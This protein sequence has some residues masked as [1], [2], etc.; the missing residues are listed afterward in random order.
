[1]PDNSLLPSRK[2]DHIK[3]NLENDVQSGISSGFENFHFQHNAIPELDLADVNSSLTLFGK[4]LSAPILISSMTGGTPEAERINHTLALA[5]QKY[6]LAMGVGS[7]RAAIENPDLAYSFQVRKVAPDILLFANLGAVQLNHS[8]TGKHCM[9]AVEMIEADGLFLHL[10][11]LQEALQPEGDTKF[12]GL[13]RQIEQVCK[14]LPVPVMVKEVGWGIS[15]S[16]ARQL[17]DAGVTAIDVAGAGGTSWS[18]VEYFRIKDEIN[19]RIALD[20]KDWGI[21]TADCLEQIASEAPEMMMFA[22]G[23]I[24]TG[25]D[26]AKAINLG[27]SLCG[28]AGPF[29]RAAVES[30]EAVETLIKYLM[31]ELHILQFAT[32]CKTLEDLKELKMYKPGECDR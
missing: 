4:Q 27:A 7:Q 22:S 13:L 5:A 24:K 9:K 16:V 10:N 1:M 28:I 20:F 15:G 31:K 12:S 11:A 14:Q 19:K 26:I 6:G 3:I 30:E 32:G 25:L 23:G 17:K 21:P 8:F 2:S 18:Q 29:I